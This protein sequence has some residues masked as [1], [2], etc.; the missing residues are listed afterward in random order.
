M[1]I[2]K[3]SVESNMYYCQSRYY[4]PEWCRW[5]NGDVSSLN[6]FD[7]NG[8]NLF[9]YCENNPLSYVQ[10]SIFTG[11]PIYLQSGSL[12][13]V[14]KTFK[15]K[16]DDFNAV[17]ASGSF[18]NGLFY[19]KGTLTECLTS[20]YA[21]AEFSYNNG[22][23]L[24]AF[25]NFSLFNAAGEIGIGNSDINLSLV[26]SVDFGTMEGFAGIVFDPENNH[27]L[28]GIKAEV[29]AVTAS[30]GVQF[31]IFNTTIE[32]G[33]SVNA[34]SVGYEFG[35]VIK[36]GQFRFSLGQ[37]LLFGWDFYFTIKFK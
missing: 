35:I 14:T 17:I 37:S 1:G 28:L 5:L 6:P 36:D 15:P 13:Y 34:L 8:L 33:G 10:G 22:F 21:K 30:G 24:G 19:G 7:I 9:T 23:L 2:R 11:I 18:R 27:Y 32:M 31:G 12:G 16:Q 3:R 20:S 4:V 26:G 25:Y 29:K